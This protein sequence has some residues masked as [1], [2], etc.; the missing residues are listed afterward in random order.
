MDAF[1]TFY[2]PR[3]I[4]QLPNSTVRVVQQIREVQTLGDT[5]T[6]NEEHVSRF[7][8]TRGLRGTFD[9]IVRFVSTE[10]GVAL[11]DVTMAREAI[12]ERNLVLHSAKRSVDIETARSYVSAIDQLLLSFRELLK[13]FLSFPQKRPGIGQR[14]RCGD[15]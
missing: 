15:Q 14:F 1:I 10:V 3:L 12:N 8:E 13:Q 2:L 5:E 9:E 4:L 6:I 7:L 11:E